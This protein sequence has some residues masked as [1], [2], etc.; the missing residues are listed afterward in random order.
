MTTDRNIMERCADVMAV[1]AVKEGF[2]EE[3]SLNKYLKEEEELASG[4]SEWPAWFRKGLDKLS[5]LPSFY[6]FVLMPCYASGTVPGGGDM[7]TN[8]ETRSCLRVLVLK[9]GLGGATPLRTYC[10]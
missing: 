7:V 3:T 2:L 1:S 9:L 8:K 10:T 6:K 4:W 5:F